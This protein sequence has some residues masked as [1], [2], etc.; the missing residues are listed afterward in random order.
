MLQNAALSI[1]KIIILFPSTHKLIPNTS[2]RMKI[3]GFFRVGF[4]IFAEGED[5]VID[6]SG[7]RVN[8]VAPN[9]LQDLLARNHFVFTIY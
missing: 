3:Y 5:E 7:G 1:N 9:R 2:Y 4:E 8:V 6:G